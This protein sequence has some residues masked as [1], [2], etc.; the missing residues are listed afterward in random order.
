MSSPLAFMVQQCRKIWLT[1]VWDSEVLLCPQGRRL[2]K[3]QSLEFQPL[4]TKQHTSESSPYSFLLLWLMGWP[5]QVAKK[6]ST[7]R[8][9]NR[10]MSMGWRGEPLSQKHRLSRRADVKFSPTHVSRKKQNPQNWILKYPNLRGKK[11]SV[12]TAR[13]VLCW[14]YPRTSL[15]HPMDACFNPLWKQIKPA[16]KKAALSGT[17]VPRGR[18]ALYVHMP[19]HC[20]KISPRIPAAGSKKA[21]VTFHLPVI[22]FY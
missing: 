1:W 16:H 7:I 13:S 21:P 8:S 19:L 20:A 6:H 4:K 14:P 10:E 22:R 12:I 5:I 11:L 2:I 3:T 17:W 9:D 15:V 18:H